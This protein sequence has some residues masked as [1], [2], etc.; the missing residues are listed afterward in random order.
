[1]EGLAGGDGVSQ[2][3]TIHE[4]RNKEQGDWDDF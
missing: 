1:M 2:C 4:E 3:S